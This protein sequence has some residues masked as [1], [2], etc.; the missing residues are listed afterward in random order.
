[1]VA[2]KEIKCLDKSRVEL[3]V[4][5]GR[6]EMKKEYDALI[7]KYSKTAQVKGFR[8]GK[9]PAA[10]LERK[11]GDSLINEAGFNVIEKSLQEALL[12]VDKKPLP[13]V[14]PA[15]K[16]EESLKLALDSDIEYTVEYDTFPDVEL[17]EYK[18]VE[19]EV[20]NVVI[21]EADI[22]RELDKYREQ[23]AV[24]TEKRGGK[25][26]KG[27]V[28]TINYVEL[29][30]A[31][32]E[33][34]KTKRDDFTFTVGTGY[35][36]YKID[37]DVIGL[38]KDEEKIIEKEFAP[39]FEYK[40]LAGRKVRLKVT[41]KTIKK[42]ELPEITDELAQDISEKYKT[43]EDL[44]E[45]VKKRLNGVTDMKLLDD[46]KRAAMAKIIESTKVDP[47]QAMIDNQL[48]T[49]WTNFIYRFGG[50]EKQVEKMLAAEGKTREDLVKDWEGEALRAV[51]SQIIIGEISKKEKIEASDADVD[52]EM[53]LEADRAGM[54]IEEFKQYVKE[55]NMN[56]Y[57]KIGV[58]DRKTYD[59][60][61]SNA[62]VKKGADV[63][64]LDFLH[65]AN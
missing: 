30:D 48:N 7:A 56:E 38:K 27:N 46:K 8:Q 13:Y 42:R 37:E 29:D 59:F 45:D 60:I 63:K 4:K 25:V 61:L 49:M 32:K 26:A 33:I 20:P 2:N 15:L 17:G 64:Y 5:V 62:K 51:K 10:V 54:K 3:S 28:I 65:Q 58:L 35:N 23:N 11:Y 52:E 6:E 57:F 40:E 44:I 18:G 12:D 9:V 21:K 16:N 50:D 47:P 19:I 43:K 39:D 53:K 31:E 55:N 24:V 14:T 34:E 22:N 36:Y 1:M 41:V